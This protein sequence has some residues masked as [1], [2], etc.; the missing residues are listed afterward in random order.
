MESPLFSRPAHLVNRASRLFLRLGDSHLQA[1]GVSSGQLPVLVALQDGKVLSQKELTALVRIKQPTMAQTLS[2]MERDGLIQ[3]QPDPNDRRG[4]L[5]SLCP[6]AAEKMDAIVET[7]LRG[8]EEAL[9]GFEEAEKAA[10]MALLRRLIGN[11][12]AMADQQQE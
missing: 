11:L 12:E 6:A 8:N 5:I 9:A 3:R 1:F 2:R 4:S 10:L 7:L